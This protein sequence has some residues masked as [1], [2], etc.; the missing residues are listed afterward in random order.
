M[1]KLENVREKA[2]FAP[3]KA[4]KNASKSIVDEA[5]EKNKSFLSSY[6]Q[7][8][9]KPSIEAYWPPA[10]SSKKDEEKIKPVQV[11]SRQE[12]DEKTVKLVNNLRLHTTTDPG[13]VHNL[14]SIFLAVE[15]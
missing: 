4:N 10:F 13:T 8:P 1:K 5:I 7:W 2:T 11:L 3:L 15:T 6:L 9:A 14:H 12:V